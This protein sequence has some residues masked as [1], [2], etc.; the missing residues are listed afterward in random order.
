MLRGEPT[1]KTVG[2]F[3]RQGGLLQ[4]RR[5]EPLDLDRSAG[6]SLRTDIGGVLNTSQECSVCV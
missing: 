6:D 5:W 1:R 2:N 4:P 3:A